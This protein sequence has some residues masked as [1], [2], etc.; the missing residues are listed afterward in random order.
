[1]I[2]ITVAVLVLGFLL[3][4]A[5]KS[6]RQKLALTDA[7]TLDLDDRGLDS[8]RLGLAGRP[9]RIVEGHIPEE[10]KSSL[11]VY[12]SHRA[13]LAVYF[14]LIEEETGVRPTYG[15]ISLKNGTRKRIENTPELREWVL[16][17]ADQIRVA[18]RRIREVS[19]NP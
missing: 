9:D 5:G 1:M 8:W 16:E 10:W 4:L 19:P 18:K 14:L 2:W 11:R 13:Q 7:T 12:D 6:T 3:N 15:F 17:V